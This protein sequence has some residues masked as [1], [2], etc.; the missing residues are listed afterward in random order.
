MTLTLTDEERSPFTAS[1]CAHSWA[2]AGSLGILCGLTRTTPGDFPGR[3]VPKRGRC[4]LGVGQR[5]CVTLAFRRDASVAAGVLGQYFSCR[6]RNKL[7]QRT[8]WS[9]FFTPIP[10]GHRAYAELNSVDGQFGVVA[11][12]VRTF[13]PPNHCFLL[14]LSWRQLGE[15]TH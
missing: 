10:K 1:P 12:P 6:F 8:V 2:P 5:C 15:S 7:R 9:I 14:N 4:S 11:G 13:G 3:I